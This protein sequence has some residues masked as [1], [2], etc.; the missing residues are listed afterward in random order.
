MSSSTVRT[1][2]TADEIKQAFLENLRC[3]LGRSAH[4]VKKAAIYYALSLTV[5]DP[6][7]DRT[8]DTMPEHGEF[9]ARNC[10]ASMAA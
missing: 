8:V 9:I 7:F 5:R 3:A 1:G 4:T 6:L 2:L 10:K